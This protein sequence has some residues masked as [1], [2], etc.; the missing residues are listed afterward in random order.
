[1][2]PDF[3]LPRDGDPH[4]PSDETDYPDDLLIDSPSGQRPFNCGEVTLANGIEL[5]ASEI[6]TIRSRLTGEIWL[7]AFVYMRRRPASEWE[8]IYRT[9]IEV[10]LA[11]VACVSSE[12]LRVTDDPQLLASTLCHLGDA[13]PKAMGENRAAEPEQNMALALAALLPPGDSTSDAPSK[14][15]QK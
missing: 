1:V 11:Q 2:T 6:Q 5:R 7:R 3:S 10:P 4:Q 14:E 8:L 9:W 12:P 15:S 13:P